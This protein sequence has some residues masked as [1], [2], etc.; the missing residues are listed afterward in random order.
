MPETAQLHLP[1]RHA[2]GNGA[3]LQRGAV[4]GDAAARLGHVDQ[5]VCVGSVKLL[6][7]IVGMAASEGAWAGVCAFGRLEISGRCCARRRTPSVRQ[8]QP[9]TPTFAWE[10]HSCL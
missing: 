9:R 6:R 4:R 10:L 8:A 5:L 2:L 1:R 7:A 3:L